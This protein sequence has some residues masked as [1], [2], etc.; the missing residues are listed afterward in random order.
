MSNHFSFFVNQINSDFHSF[1]FYLFLPLSVSFSLSLYIYI[2]IA[3]PIFSLH[4][5]DD[6]DDDDSSKRADSMDSLISLMF[7]VHL[8]WKFVR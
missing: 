4:V 8:F 6:D 2:Y 7:L 1:C 3:L 5:D